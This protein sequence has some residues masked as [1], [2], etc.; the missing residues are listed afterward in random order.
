MMVRDMV[1][2]DT[3]NQNKLR[4]LW[5]IG[6]VHGDFKPLAETLLKHHRDGLDMPTWVIFLGDIDIKDSRQN[7]MTIISCE[8]EATCNSI[9][10]GSWRA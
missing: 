10:H 7:N 3:E 4:R 2:F 9:R 8:A 6:D 1:E 5:F